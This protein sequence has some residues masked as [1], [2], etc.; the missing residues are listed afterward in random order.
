MSACCG[1][2]GI[3]HTAFLLAAFFPTLP[4]HPNIREYT[5]ARRTR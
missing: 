5:K 1:A 2:L 3:G 4:V